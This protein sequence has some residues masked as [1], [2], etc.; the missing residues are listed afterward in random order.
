MK[1][2]HIAGHLRS[3]I[4]EREGYSHNAALSANEIDGQITMIVDLVAQEKEISVVL[5]LFS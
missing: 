1:L 5:F 3:S 4:L 2:L